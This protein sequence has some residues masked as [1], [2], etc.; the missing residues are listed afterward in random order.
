MSNVTFIKPDSLELSLEAAKA[1]IRSA[2][3][4]DE[5]LM[6]DDKGRVAKELRTIEDRVDGLLFAIN[7]E[8]E[9]TAEG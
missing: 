3:N 8:R 4:N 5:L 7:P 1:A 9:T 6:I 2:L